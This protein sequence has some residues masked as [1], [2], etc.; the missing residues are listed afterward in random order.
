MNLALENLK[1]RGF[2]QQCSDTE[3]LSRLMD[4]EAVT[5]YVG[6]DPTA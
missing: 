3:G 1:Q 6:C 5:F 4:E 2:L